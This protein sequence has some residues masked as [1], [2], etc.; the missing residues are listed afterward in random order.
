MQVETPN[1]RLELPD[2]MRSKLEAFRRRGIFPREARSLSE[3]SLRWEGPDLTIDE[4][5]PQ[6][7]IGRDLS[8]QMRDWNL[9]GN[10]KVIF[11]RL[12]EARATAQSIIEGSRKY[13]Q[14][15]TIGLD[16]DQ[17]DFEVNSIRP[18]RRVGPEGQFIMDAVVEII[19][20]RPGYIDK[21]IH[22][23][24]TWVP[25]GE[26]PDFWFRGGC[27]LVI[28]QETGRLRYC[29][30]KRIT[31]EY[32]YERQRALLAGRNAGPSLAATYFDTARTDEVN[33]VFSFVHRDLGE[34]V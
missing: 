6:I 31:S 32:R 15:I 22:E 12:Q 24:P 34:G 5:A 23:A 21:S 29:I 1:H 19:Q 11:D 4:T 7:Y 9:S 17:F 18:V 27:T 8:L 10:R 26:E 16:L 28:D 30:F 13:K 25:D 3:E 14:R 2:G 33:E 20:K